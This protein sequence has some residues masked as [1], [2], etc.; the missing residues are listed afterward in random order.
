LRE[1]GVAFEARLP[2]AIGSGS[3]MEP[4]FLEANPRAEVP[5]LVDGDVRVFDSTIILEYIE[6]RWP[7]PKLLPASPAERARVRMLEG[8]G[9]PRGDQLGPQESTSS[10]ARRASSRRAWASARRSDRSWRRWLE[11]QLGAPGS[12][13]AFGW[14]DVA[15]ARLNGS[16]LRLE[17]A[18]R[19]SPLGSPA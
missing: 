8:R 15:V 12:T 3:G 19:S 16:R 9:P 17:P 18:G 7:E 10:G 13:T 2:A 4:A 6:E 11:R 5:A 14:G 1:K